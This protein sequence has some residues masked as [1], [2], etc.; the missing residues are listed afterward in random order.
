MMRRKEN[1]HRRKLDVVFDRSHI[2]ILHVTKPKCT[3]TIFKRVDN[4]GTNIIGFVR[5]FSIS[6]SILEGLVCHIGPEDANPS[7]AALRIRYVHPFA[8][9]PLA[10]LVSARR[11]L[12][13]FILFK[14]LG[15]RG[16]GNIIVNTIKIRDK[17]QFI[18]ILNALNMILVR[19]R[20]NKTN[21]ILFP[22]EGL[23]SDLS[24]T[25]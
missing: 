4:R 6:P 23:I 16:L 19:M 8:P 11:A 20:T 5:V 24:R 22:C 15:L 13:L 1:V 14:T 2:V 25:H 17:P 18:K 7:R 10:N 12:Q 21:D 9:T 3:D